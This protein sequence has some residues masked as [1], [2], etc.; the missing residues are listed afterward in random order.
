MIEI[1][2]IDDSYLLSEIIEGRPVK[3][4]ELPNTV[5]LAVGLILSDWDNRYR[6]C[7]LIKK[8]VTVATGIKEL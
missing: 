1:R 4:I 3:T 7:K 2:E 6:Y 5:A 8:T